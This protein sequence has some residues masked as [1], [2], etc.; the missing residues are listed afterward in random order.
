MAGNVRRRGARR[1]RKKKGNW[2]TRMKTWKKV[3]LCFTILLICLLGTGIGYVYAKWSK[4]DTRVI[5]PDD[6]IINAEVG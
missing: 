1:L 3:L 6:I 4:V 2:F 5:E